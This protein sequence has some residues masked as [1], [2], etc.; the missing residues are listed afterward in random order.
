MELLNNL[1][2]YIEVYSIKTKIIYIIYLNIYNN[3]LL[4]SFLNKK[5]KI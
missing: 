2:I 1:D 3:K 4:R 5:Y